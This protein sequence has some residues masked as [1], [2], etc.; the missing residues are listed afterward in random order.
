MIDGLG[1]LTAWQG[2]DLHDHSARIQDAFHS[3]ARPAAIRWCDDCATLRGC[4]NS[5]AA[6]VAWPF[7][8]DKKCL[9][10]TG[11][12]PGDQVVHTV[13]SPVENETQ[14]KTSAKASNLSGNA[15]E[16]ASGPSVKSKVIQVLLLFI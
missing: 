6:L 2:L 5:L 3:F 4:T 9:W 10:I 12:V 13:F 14:S 11:S 8:F 7:L 1:T 15:L 16:T